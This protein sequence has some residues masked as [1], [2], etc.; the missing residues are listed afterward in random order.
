MLLAFAVRRL[1]AAVPVLLFVAIATFGLMY[2]VPGDAAR[3]ILGDGATQEQVAQLH[4]ELGLD[5]P[6]FERF[7]SWLGDALHGDLGSSIFLSDPVST[8][9]GQRL[10]VTLTLSVAA[11]LVAVILGIGAGLYMATRQATRRDRFLS[12][13]TVI[14]IAVPS[15][16]VAIVLVAVFAVYLGW[17][18][19]TG[20]VAPWDDPLGSLKRLA[21]PIIALAL[22]QAALIARVM[23]GSMV[24]VLETEY[25]LAASTRGISRAKQ[26]LVH[27]LPNALGPTISVIGVSFGGLVSGVVVIES[28]FN[29]PGLGRMIIQAVSTRDIVLLQGVVVIT[30]VLYVLVNLLTDLV[31]AWVNPRL[32]LS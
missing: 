32:K 6:F 13:G 21:L 3:V 14:G 4:A 26:L 2:L 23:R 17:L 8:V 5:E 30:A 11:E 18:P 7:F 29:I 1:L 12:A 10:K 28:V 19:A 9:I 22:H 20:F 24:E 15:F 31:Q 27:A 25:M 16:V